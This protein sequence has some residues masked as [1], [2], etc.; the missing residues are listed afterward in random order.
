MNSVR[1]RP[2]VRRFLHAFRP[3]IRRRQFS[4][5]EKYVAVQTAANEAKLDRVWVR[6]GE[7]DTIARRLRDMLPVLRFGLCHGVRNGAEVQ[8]FRELLDCEVIGTDISRT[9]EQ[10][11]GVVRQD[12]HEARPEW[13]GACD[14]IYSNSLDHSFDPELALWTWLSCLADHGVILLHWSPEHDRRS[15]G[16]QNADC[17]QATRAGYERLIRAVGSLR[18]VLTLPDDR[19]VFVC[20]AKQVTP[21]FRPAATASATRIDEPLRLRLQGALRTDA[22]VPASDSCGHNGWLAPVAD[23]RG[24]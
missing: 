6:P 11:P 9:A 22:P 23:V 13:L 19:C 3:A 8:R 2:L 20:A 24:S 5:Y 14:F 15:F 4:S 7:L 18:D 21:S 10:F 12:F 16:M 1:L 17:F